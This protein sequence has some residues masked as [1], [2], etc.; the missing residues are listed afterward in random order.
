MYDIKI[1]RMIIYKIF[2]TKPKVFYSFKLFIQSKFFTISAKLYSPY[3][4]YF[5]NGNK[6]ESEEQT[7]NSSQVT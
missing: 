3:E 4:E 1:K 7:K 5:K 2:I 6:T